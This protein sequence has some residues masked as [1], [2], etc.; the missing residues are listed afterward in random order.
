VEPGSDVEQALGLL[1]TK[2]QHPVLTDIEI[3]DTPVEMYDLFPITL[4]DLF[5]GEEMVV[6]A[7]YRTHR[8]AIAGEVG[9]A[10]RR[11]GRLERFSVDVAFPI[12]EAV[13]DFIPQLWA[14]RKIGYLSRE[15]RLHGHDPELVDEIRRTA[16]RYGLLSEFTSYLVQ[17]PEMIVNNSPALAPID[18]AM[19]RMQP[20]SAQESTGAGSVAIAK[21]SAARREVR[22]VGDVKDLNEEFAQRW[23]DE[24]R[25]IVAGR[26]FVRSDSIWTDAT[27]K[28]EV[29]T[30][31][32][33]PFSSA[34]FAVLEAL[35]E[36]EPYFIEFETVVV[37]GERLTIALV[38]DGQTTLDAD[39]VTRLVRGFRGD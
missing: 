39:K 23:S 13:N 2:I 1:T 36:L 33:A 25:Q 29:P 6:F 3:S 4:P 35:P 5:R 12:D 7:R 32:I 31:R 30:I 16:L 34:Y 10:G 26:I 11:N 38:A 28:T 21:Q 18:M 15:L 22:S 9:I 17:E 37:G 24:D 8:N 20:L 27:A 14:A 19:L